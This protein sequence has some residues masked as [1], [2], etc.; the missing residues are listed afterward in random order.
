MKKISFREFLG[1]F[2]FPSDFT[3][4]AENF[5]LKYS[6]VGCLKSILM[7]GFKNMGW[8]RIS[9]IDLKAGKLLLVKCNQG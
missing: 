4:V 3:V 6:W 8:S 1:V 9:H 2:Y 5:Y 7:C